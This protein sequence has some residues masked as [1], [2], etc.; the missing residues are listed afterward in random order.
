MRANSTCSRDCI[1]FLSVRAATTFSGTCGSWDIL[2]QC[3][4]GATPSSGHWA[5]WFWWYA[6]KRSEGVLRRALP[7]R[8][9]IPHE[10][11]VG[12]QWAPSRSSRSGCSACATP[13]REAP[14][15]AASSS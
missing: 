3:V 8:F 10:E 14:V 15:H 7:K 5:I 12:V 1:R 11:C 9:V 4:R 6:A 13:A 2:H